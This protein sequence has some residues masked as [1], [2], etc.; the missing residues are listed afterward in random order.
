MA[1]SY[2]ITEKE[3]TA[4]LTMEGRLVDKAE[5]VEV[6]MEVE[7]ELGKGTKQFVI[8]LTGLEYMNSTGLNILIN[9][10]NKTR[11]MGGDAVVAGATPRIH[12]L[13]T[14]TKLHTVF[15]MKATTAEAMLHFDQTASK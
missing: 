1:F 11:N 7:E 4:V 10:M 2:Q 13:F 8:D 3:G 6:S 14:V 9:M 5:A 12:S 15:T